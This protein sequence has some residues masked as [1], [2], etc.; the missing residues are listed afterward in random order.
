MSNLRSVVVALM[1]VDASATPG[2]QLGAPPRIPASDI[3]SHVGSIATVCGRVVTYRC[4]LPSRT[5]FL[6]L[7]T[8]Y[9]DEGVSLRIPPDARSR[10]HPR[11][12]DTYFSKKLCA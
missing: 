3:A 2:A 12:E 7:D 8:P 1:L 9:W 4:P 5:T 10:F 11:I 6:D